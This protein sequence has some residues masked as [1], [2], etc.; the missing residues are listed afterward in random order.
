MLPVPKLVRKLRDWLRLPPAPNAS[1][2]SPE[3]S[4]APAWSVLHVVAGLTL[5][6]DTVVALHL[7]GAPETEGRF[8]QL[9]TWSDTQCL[10]VRELRPTALG[11]GEY[12]VF[13]VYAS[14]PLEQIAHWTVGT[15]GGSASMARRMPISVGQ[16]TRF[17]RVLN[18][19]ILVPGDPQLIALRGAQTLHYAY[20]HSLRWVRHS[21]LERS[22]DLPA[23]LAQGVAICKACLPV[24]SV[25]ETVARQD[26]RRNDIEA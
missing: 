26:S 16:R 12:V 7:A 9:E 8:L 17:A 14:C 19:L 6:G 23:V 25:G 21:C 18:R 20:C 15:P 5:T 24:P 13:A 4:C 22:P 11:D 10:E 2:S 1:L 3:P